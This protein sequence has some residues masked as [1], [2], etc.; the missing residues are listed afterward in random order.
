VLIDAD[1]ADATMSGATVTLSLVDGDAAG[2]PAS[3]SAACAE[4]VLSLNAT[5]SGIA[6][7]WSC[8]TLNL[9]ASPPV[10]ISTLR[11]ALNNVT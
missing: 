8:P 1:D 5:F 10:S 9:T 3:G 6:S 7:S 4:D 11:D 2:T